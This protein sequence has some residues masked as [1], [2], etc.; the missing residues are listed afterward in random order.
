[1]LHERLK[2]ETAASHKDTEKTLHFEKTI[3]SKESYL[4]LLKGFYG[5]YQPVEKELLKFK[6]EFEA[7]GL[8]ILPRLKESLLLQDMKTLGLT[9]PSKLEVCYAL[10]G[11]QTLASAMG[12][13]YVLEGSTMGGQ[14]ISK[15][16]KEAHILETEKSFHNPYGKETMPMW[17]GFKAGLDK[18]NAQDEDEVVKAAKETFTRLG[19]WLDVKLADKI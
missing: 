5:F 14:I 10:P 17:M 16:L 4:K 7:L 15:K 3:S 13:L 12:V 18:I 1:M 8:H 19:A 2:T 9:D 11:I 6:S